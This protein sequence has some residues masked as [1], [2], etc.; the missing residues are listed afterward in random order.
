M[1]VGTDVVDEAFR[2]CMETTKE[3]PN[4]MFF[5]GQLVF[6]QEAWYQ[7][8]LHN[9]TAFSLQR[10]LFLEGQTMVVLPMRM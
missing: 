10:R 6:R 2:L 5:S 7:P 1:A 4:I 9:R 8:L 3:F